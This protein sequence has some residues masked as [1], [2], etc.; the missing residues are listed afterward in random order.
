MK[1][2]LAIIFAFILFICGC[3]PQPETPEDPSETFFEQTAPSTLPT[4]E[5]NTEPTVTVTEA[6]E[7]SE[8]PTEPIFDPYDIIQTMSDEELV[9]QMFLARCPGKETGAADV[10]AYHLGGYVLFGSDV[11]NETPDSLLATI[12]SYQQASKIPLLIAVDEEGGTVTRISSRSQYADAKFNSPRLIFDQE[13]IEGILNVET[14]KIKLL[15]SLGFNLNLAP[16]CDI[17]T[18]PNAFMYDRSLGQS[19]EITSNYIVSVLELYRSQGFGAMLKHFPGY[20]NNTDTHIGIALDERPL[21]LLECNDLAPFAAGI[22]NGCHAIMVSHTI[23]KALDPE[24]PA[25]LSASVVEYLRKNMLF[26]GV[27]C[28]DDLIMQAITD[29]YGD[30]EAAV[31]AVTA[32]IDLL[33]SSSY[34]VEYEAVL[35]AVKDGTIDRSSIEASV[36]RILLWKHSLGMI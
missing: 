2:L 13:G 14:E 29:L 5:A 4:L 35:A 24:L 32:G 23:I 1:K 16:V 9:G 6:T 15:R 12:N 36:A 34:Q 28:T 31:M 7:P 22:Q 18:D 33:C 26:E 17:T 27:I 10:A 8:A 11:E 3:T 20:G 25:S 19:P 21:E 30:A